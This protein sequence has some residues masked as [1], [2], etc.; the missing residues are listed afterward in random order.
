LT[1]PASPAGPRWG[2]ETALAIDNFRISGEPMPWEVVEAL[3]LVKLAAAGANGEL[4]AIPE[5]IAAAVAAACEEV[6]AGSQRDQFPVDVFQTGSGTSTN[7]NVNE[8][9]ASIASER[10]GR[11]IHPNDHVNACQSSNDVVPTAIRVAAVLSVLDR[12]SPALARLE[13]A[14][15]ELARRHQRTVKL[16]RTHLMDAVPMTFGTEVGAWATAVRHAR[17]RVLVALRHMQRLPI[18]GTAVGTGLNAVPGFAGATLERLRHR[19]GVGFVE[20]DAPA[21]AQSTQDDVLELSGACRGVALALNKIAGDLRLLASGPSGGLGELTLPALQAGSSIMPGKVNPVIPEVVQLVAA[22]VVGNDAALV[23][24]STLSTLQ[25]STAMPI[26]AR[27]TMSSITLLASAADHLAERCIA[28][29][30][31]DAKRMRR[32]AA[33]APTLVTALAPAIGY[34]AAVRIVQRSSELGIPL[35]ESAEQ[36]GVRGVDALLDL[37]EIAAP[38]R[39]RARRRAAPPR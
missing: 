24:A 35:H 12:L 31:V 38:R 36:E 33:S 15:L 16:G 20:S 19:T 10:L 34:D 32:L 37:D 27:C 8:V 11:D 1:E 3:V 13:E 14:L 9:V 29:I 4:G 28:G 6:L 25:L 2:R 7:M 23:F 26:A 30:E 22:Q 21:H 5:D 18:G 39:R 17:D